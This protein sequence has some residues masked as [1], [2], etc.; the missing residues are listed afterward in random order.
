FSGQEPQGRY[1][2][3]YNSDYRP[4]SE[5]SLQV[6]QLNPR[7]E[8]R[9]APASITPLQTDREIW[10]VFNY[11]F[12]KTSNSSYGP[13]ARPPSCY[14]FPSS[15]S[16][17]DIFAASVSGVTGVAGSAQ[18]KGWTQD[19]KTGQLLGVEKNGHLHCEFPHL[20]ET[21]MQTELAG[22]EELIQLLLL[23]G[24]VLAQYKTKDEP[25]HKIDVLCE[26]G[27]FVISSD[28]APACCAEFLSFVCRE[29]GLQH[30]LNLPVAS[31]PIIANEDAEN[32]ECGACFGSLGPE[33]S[34]VLQ[35]T[36]WWCSFCGRR[37]ECPRRFCLEMQTLPPH[38]SQGSSPPPP[39]H[40]QPAVRCT[41][42]L[43]TEYQTSY[44]A[45]WPQPTI[46]LRDYHHHHRPCHWNPHSSL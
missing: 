34:A 14:L 19:V 39:A 30:L 22:V 12:Y 23:T 33:N 25:Q 10:P 6:D 32:W 2:T 41:E 37:T 17:F 38:T 31:S 44:C 8:A 29:A 24:N 16:P 13:A 46:Q 7:T 4:F 5:R 36:S 18:T 45:Q 43:L 15:R 28:T 9:P 21:H 42:P 40:A 27:A 35:P 20:S 3:S 26:R 11:Y 1:V